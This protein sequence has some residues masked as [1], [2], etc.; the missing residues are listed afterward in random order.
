VYACENRVTILG[1]L[2]TNYGRENGHNGPESPVDILR[3][4]SRNRW[5][6]ETGVFRAAGFW[7]RYVDLIRYDDLIL[8]MLLY[9][10]N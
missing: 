9:A 10:L 7:H 6:T 8:T 5:D 4:L 2:T 3:M 1:D